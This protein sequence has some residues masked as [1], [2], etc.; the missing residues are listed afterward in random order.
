MNVPSSNKV[1][2]F[3]RWGD[4]VFEV[5]N[6]DNEVS[7]KRFEGINLSGNALPSGTYFYKIEFTEPGRK[8]M[9]GYLT[10]KQ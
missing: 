4:K 3:N 7:G 6:Y 1:T 8:M 2:I 10:L 5:E 9:S